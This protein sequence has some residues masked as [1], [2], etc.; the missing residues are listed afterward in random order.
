MDIKLYRCGYCG[1][2]TDE[3]GNPIHYA[4][5]DQSKDWNTAELTHGICCAYN[6][7]PRYREVTRE[8]AMDAGFPE[9]EG[10]LVRD[11]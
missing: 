8:M 4:Q 9:I 1:S 6:F 11:N 3:I 10:T 5:I 7:E 2:P